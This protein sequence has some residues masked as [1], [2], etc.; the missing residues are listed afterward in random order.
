ML[1]QEAPP[2]AIVAQSTAK[3]P[4]VLKRPPALNVGHPHEY[5]RPA[6]VEHICERLSRGETLTRI[7]Q[8]EGLPTPR[9]LWN[10][11]AE[12]PTIASALAH[13]RKVGHDAIAD[14]TLE[15]ADSGTTD[16][17]VQRDKLRIWTRL[18]LL[19]CW[20]PSRYSPKVAVEHSGTVTQVTASDVRR[21]LQDCPLLAEIEQAPAI[22]DVAEQ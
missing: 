5:D 7:C 3:P 18:E 8:T 17:A 10:W 6:C 11:R 9:E 22:V 12:D 20:D 19:K 16:E 1:T 14:N 21:A 13:A 15:I 2:T 4:R